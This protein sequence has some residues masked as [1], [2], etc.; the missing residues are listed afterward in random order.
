VS[1]ESRTRANITHSSTTSVKQL[2]PPP[3]HPPPPPP[4]PP[5]PPPP[6]P[7]LLL[8]LLLP[9][10][11]PPPPSSSFLLLFPPPP[12][13]SSCSSVQ[14]GD[15]H[16]TRLLL[17]RRQHADALGRHPLDVL[18]GH[19]RAHDVAHLERLLAVEERR[20]VQLVVLRPVHPDEN[21]RAR[22]R[23]R[24]FFCCC[25]RHRP[26]CWRCFGCTPTTTTT[27]TTATTAVSSRRRQSR[28]SCGCSCYFRG[29]HSHSRRRHRC[30][31]QC[32]RRG[33]SDGART[34]VADGVGHNS[35][36]GGGRRG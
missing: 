32:R 20:R 16:V 7:L 11:P 1:G 10:P 27:T 17:E 21:Q 28:R 6:P 18:G 12:P 25:T 19:Y 29:V 8:P 23:C 34:D 22:R 9:P 36:G 33:A 35:V 4:P 30:G 2:P 14:V 5:R 26:S 31:R 13:S 24:C 15:P 3:P